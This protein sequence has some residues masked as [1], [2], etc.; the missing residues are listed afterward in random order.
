VSRTL[1][2]YPS[3]V[4]AVVPGDAK[5]VAA[6]VP[7]L[8]VGVDGSDGASRAVHWAADTA[9]AA[10]GDVVG[11]HAFECPVA[12]ASYEEAASLSDERGQR[13]EVEWCAPLRAAAVPYRASVENG[14]PRH[15]LRWAAEAEQPICVVVGSRGLGAISQRVLG[16]VTYDLV[17]HLASPTIIVPSARDRVVWPPR[18]G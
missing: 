14:D 7:R 5:E 11:V 17:R 9:A 3:H 2:T 15:V 16:S 8:V 4:V 12:G 6:T 10:G 13:L 18:T 1:T